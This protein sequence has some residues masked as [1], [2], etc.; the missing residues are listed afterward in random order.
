M[1]FESR[2][3]KE[4]FLANFLLTCFDRWERGVR[5]SLYLTPLSLAQMELD[6]MFLYQLLHFIEPT[7][8]TTWCYYIQSLL[9]AAHHRLLPPMRQVEGG[10]G[11]EEQRKEQELRQFWEGDE[12]RL[13]MAFVHTHRS[14]LTASHD[15]DDEHHD[16][17]G[18][19]KELHVFV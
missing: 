13:R 9:L 10:E 5:T 6:V 15:T 19:W 12:D 3:L 16:K 8:D 1:Q 14:L 2:V 18:H 7:P 11:E 4:D 17:D